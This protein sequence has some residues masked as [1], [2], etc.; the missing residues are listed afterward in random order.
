[1]MECVP[2]TQMQTKTAVSPKLETIPEDNE[3]E[4]K[5]QLKSEKIKYLDNLMQNMDVISN[6]KEHDKL[7]V[8]SD[9]QFSIDNLYYTQGIVR[10]LYGNGRDATIAGLTKLISDVFK[11]TDDLLLEE[12]EKRQNN[13]LNISYDIKC[14]PYNNKMKNYKDT[15][16]DILSKISTGLSKAAK[17]LQN[18]KITYVNDQ[19]ISIQLDLL[20]SKMEHRTDTINKTI[21]NQRPF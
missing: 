7:T 4:S 2:T 14:T 8:D 1:M 15:S 19:Q 17:G 5:I 10:R 9:N 20:I 6:I 13:M 11:F 16:S 12:R 21:K 18:L 3:S